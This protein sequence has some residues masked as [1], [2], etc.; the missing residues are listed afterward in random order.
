LRAGHQPKHRRAPGRAYLPQP[1]RRA[2]NLHEQIVAIGQLMNPLAQAILRGDIQD[3]KQV[4]VDYK[5][6]QFMFESQSD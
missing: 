5:D 6:G 3:G 1:R 2:G 4:V